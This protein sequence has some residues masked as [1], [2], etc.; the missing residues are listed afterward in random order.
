MSFWALNFIIVLRGID[1]IKWLESWAA[2]F[3][4]AMGLALLIWAVVKVGGISNMFP[5]PQE[6]PEPFW[7]I[8]F[9][10][11]TAMVGFWATLSLNIP[12]FTRYCKNAKR[13]SPRPTYWI[14]NNDGPLFFYWNRGD[15]G[16]HWLFSDLQLRIQ[17]YSL[18]SLV[19]QLL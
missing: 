11:L 9:P 16:Y 2:P 12:D 17:F 19:Q 1:C 3:L 8:F 5:E 4:I 6:N 7:P 13:S 18:V 10:Q 14:T 15:F